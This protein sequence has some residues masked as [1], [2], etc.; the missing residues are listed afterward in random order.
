METTSTHPP[1]PAPRRSHHRLMSIMAVSLATAVVM[2]SC[3]GLSNDSAGD[4]I[5]SA[6]PDGE[7]VLEA[8]LSPGTDPF[9]SSI[10]RADFEVAQV[11]D[12]VH[13]EV[14]VEEPTDAALAAV[15]GTTPGLY[16]GTG[17]EATCDAD[18]LATFL[19]E[20]P[21]KATAWAESLGIHPSE[22]S[23][24]V[25]ELAPVVLLHDT[26]VT[27]H[28]FHNGTATPFQ[29]V[30]Q[31]GTAVMVDAKGVPR[32]RCECGNP[33][34]P[35]K[36]HD[37]TPT[38]VGEPWPHFEDHPTV[39]VEPGAPV[40]IIVVINIHTDEEEEVPV[41]TQQPGPHDPSDELVPD[42]QGETDDPPVTDDS[43]R[44]DEDDDQADG[45]AGDG[46]TVEDQAWTCLSR[47]AELVVLLMPL[48][49]SPHDMVDSEGN[50][51]PDLAEQA[52]V[53]IDAEEYQLALDIICPMVQQMEDLHQHISGS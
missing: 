41:G 26:R 16:G 1:E 40:E 18:A 19:A 29:A 50:A 9:T 45:D 38:H 36:P 46:Q 52:A 4:S 32:V 7:V 2:S 14:A 25:S 24:Y 13:D 11:A 5:A 17:D 3:G 35:P 21:T 48:G 31:A 44:P 37:S 39:V 15:E 53:H 12:V 22:I 28:G 33:L 51:W 10:A 20:S 49:V 27:N 34:T 43:G 42:G 6:R 47:Y 8:A 23:D 30:L